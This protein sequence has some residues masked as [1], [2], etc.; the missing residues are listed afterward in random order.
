[1]TA[2]ITPTMKPRMPVPMSQ[3]AT[4]SDAIPIRMVTIQPVS[5]RVK[6]PSKPSDDGAYDD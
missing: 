3:P 1:M 2:T 5:T 6:Q 4:S